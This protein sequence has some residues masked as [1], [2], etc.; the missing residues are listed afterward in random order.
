MKSY[1]FSIS[2]KD[3]KN[4][5][6]C[7]GRLTLRMLPLDFKKRHVCGKC[8]HITYTNPKPVA[9]LI[10]LMADGRVALLRRNIEPAL[11]KWS[12]PA[13]FQELG[14]TVEE[15]AIRETMEEIDARARVTRLV[16]IY[17]YPDSS[18]VTIVYE[19]KILKGEKPRTTPESQ[20]VRFFNRK[21]I[22]WKDLAFLSTREA[23]KDWM[24]MK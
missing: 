19:G 12:F 3:L 2:T 10:P 15:A 18:V 22:P 17:S 9:G 13:G 11:G 1:W 5:F 20:E 21:D 24:E 8:R 7:G 23:L 6:V 16:G 14:E 4:C